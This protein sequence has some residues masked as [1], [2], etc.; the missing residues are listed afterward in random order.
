[1]L[2]VF[3]VTLGQKVSSVAAV[4]TSIEERGAS[5]YTIVVTA[6]ADDPATIHCLPIHRC[7]VS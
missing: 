2:F 7:S 6:N 3:Y 4:C 5:G 1:M